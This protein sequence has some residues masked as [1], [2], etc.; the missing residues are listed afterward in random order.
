[1][2]ERQAQNFE[3][4]AEP[5]DVH[6]GEDGSRLGTPA[7]ETVIYFVFEGKSQKGFVLPPRV[8]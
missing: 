5:S 3:T 7:E 1:M 4:S 8:G 2:L 6:I